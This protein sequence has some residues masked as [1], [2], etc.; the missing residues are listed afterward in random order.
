MVKYGGNAMVSEVLKE[1]VIQDIVLLNLVGT[2]G[3][4]CAWRR[5]G[6]IGNAEKNRQRIDFVKGLRYTDEE[7]MDIVQMIL[8]RQSK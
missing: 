8:L 4:P 6:D 2:Q 7:T 5:P 1:A 3:R